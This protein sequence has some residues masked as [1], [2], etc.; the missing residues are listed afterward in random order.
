MKSFTNNNLQK[1]NL[2]ELYMFYN[3]NITSLNNFTN[4]TRLSLHGCNVDFRS[5]TKLN[6]LRLIESECIN[7]DFINLTNL[8]T[9]QLQF[10]PNITEDIF[11][12]LPN[13][14][15]MSYYNNNLEDGLINWVF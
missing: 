8:R 5:L 4:L 10:C 14:S 6:Y 12:I 1:L 13:T 7:V 9:L 3:T 2:N 15:I 11:D